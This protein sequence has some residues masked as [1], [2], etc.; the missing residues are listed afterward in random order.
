MLNSYCTI[1]NGGHLMRPY[2]VS[3]VVSPS[4]ETILQNGPTVI[5]RPIRPA[6]A[7]QV[8]EMLVSVT[9]GGT[10]RRAAVEGYTIAGKTGTAQQVVNGAYSQTDY[11][12]SFVGFVPAEDP[13]FGMLVVIDRPRGLRTGGAVSAPVFSRLALVVA[14]YLELPITAPSDAELEAL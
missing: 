5:G 9:E 10:G 14:R 6:V 7:A 4:G 13:V 8:R 12:A 2:V 11:W 1:A 3:K